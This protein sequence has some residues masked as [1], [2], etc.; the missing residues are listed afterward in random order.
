[1]ASRMSY[2]R[3][4][5]KSRASVNEWAKMQQKEQ[6]RLTIHFQDRKA[7]VYVLAGC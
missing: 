1:M 6:P 7:T 5:S 4:H 3:F 2:V